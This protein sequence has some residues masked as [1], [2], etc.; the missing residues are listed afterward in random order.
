MT[1]E[2]G[3]EWSTPTIAGIVNRELYKQTQPGRIVDPRIFNAAQR[4]FAKRR[5]NP[6][7]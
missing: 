4:A 7:R 6:G 5:R 2:T 3:R 1:A